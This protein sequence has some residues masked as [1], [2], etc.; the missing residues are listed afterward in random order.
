MSSKTVYICDACG[1]TLKT[2]LCDKQYVR[3]CVAGLFDA[4][5]NSNKH[6]IYTDFD[7]CEECSKKVIDLLKL[8][9]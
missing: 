6:D 8:H 2:P 9:I 1:K 4:V 5:Y 7:L 3:L